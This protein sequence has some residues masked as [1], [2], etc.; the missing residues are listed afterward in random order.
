MP[1]SR[2][3]H[4]HTGH[5]TLPQ[6]M[7][8]LRRAIAAHRRLY[9]M[10]ISD[11]RA[12]FAAI[13]RDGSGAISREEFREALMRLD[14]TQYG[15]GVSDEELEVL[16]SGIDT[17]ADGKIEWAE[18]LLASG[19]EDR[20]PTE[21]EAAIRAEQQRLRQKAE[22]SMSAADLVGWRLMPRAAY[23]GIILASPLSLPLYCATVSGRRPS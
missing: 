12:L 19:M 20:G 21:A 4:T 2:P 16:C 22:A 1:H 14:L 10:E 23:L 18:F 8:Q 7:G 13:D 17:N 3:G 5:L 15:W 11:G 6:L 9:G